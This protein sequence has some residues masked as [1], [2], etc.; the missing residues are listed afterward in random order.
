MGYPILSHREVLHKTVSV[1]LTQLALR[2]ASCC[3]FHSEEPNRE[4]TTSSPPDGV[5]GLDRISTLLQV[6]YYSARHRICRA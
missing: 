4:Q 5:A 2:L 3:R 6:S 1:R